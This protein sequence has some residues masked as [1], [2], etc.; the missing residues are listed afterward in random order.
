[1]GEEMKL[2]TQLGITRKRPQS[3]SWLAGKRKEA[4]HV[5][6]IW[7]QEDEQVNGLRALLSGEVL[8][9]SVVLPL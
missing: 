3:S 1:M 2:C 6:E 7:G 9:S 4:I 8:P 5:G